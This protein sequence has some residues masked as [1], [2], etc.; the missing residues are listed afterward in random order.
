MHVLK[1]GKNN[2]KKNNK[3]KIVNTAAL[4]VSLLLSSTL[5]VGNA[6]SVYASPTISTDEQNAIDAFL[7]TQ[8]VD[9]DTRN[10]ATTNP[11]PVV[12]I[13]YTYPGPNNYVSA[14]TERNSTI[15]LTQDDVYSLGIRRYSGHYITVKIKDWSSIDWYK[16][17]NT[18]EYIAHNHGATADNMYYARKITVINQADNSEMEIDYP[19]LDIVRRTMN[20]DYLRDRHLVDMPV[21]AEDPRFQI[22]YG[23]TLPHLTDPIPTDR[24][25]AAE[26]TRY[27]YGAGYWHLAVPLEENQP[28]DTIVQIDE[29]LKTNETVVS[30]GAFG[31]KKAA[32]Y[33]GVG[34]TDATAYQEFRQHTPDDVYNHLKVEFDN[35]TVDNPMI[36]GDY[37][38]ASYIGEAQFNLPVNRIIRVG[39][40]YT[41]Y[42]TEDGTVL[43]PTT[44]GLNPVDTIAGYQF[45]SSHREANGDLVHVYTVPTTPAPSAP[46]TPATGDKTSVFASAIAMISA[47][48]VS[49]ITFVKRNKRV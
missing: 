44:Y 46:A 39:I 25:W 1:T 5:L 12:P 45:V 48:F 6:V 9:G 23:T 19:I 32:I 16:I 14:F 8:P 41:H 36:Q 11:A 27:V 13:S 3:K 20:P 15:Q 38:W 37:A 29:S 4:G 17:Y 30:E 26:A 35:A 22:I 31:T 21:E 33:V 42:V 24:S 10:I 40:D 2:M 28:Y 43:K 18:P 34:A 47:I 7:A 49:V